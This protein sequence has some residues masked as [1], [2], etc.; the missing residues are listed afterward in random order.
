M[1]YPRQ[2]LLPASVVIPGLGTIFA[3]D[4]VTDNVRDN[5]P[6]DHLCVGMSIDK[7]PGPIWRIVDCRIHDSVQGRNTMD[8]HASIP[9]NYHKQ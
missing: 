8:D 9:L 5:Y 7:P 1:Q 2:A 6:A 4:T 3:P